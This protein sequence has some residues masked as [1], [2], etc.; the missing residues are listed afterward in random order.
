MIKQNINSTKFNA[1]Q[2]RFWFPHELKLR[3]LGQALLLSA[4]LT[5]IGCGGGGSS[6]ATNVPPG[7]GGG[8]GGGGGETN[9]AAFNA[10]LYPVLVNRCG[11]CHASQGPLGTPDFAHE[12]LATALG[13][14]EANTLA[15]LGNPA[16]SRLVTKLTL[17]LHRCGSSCDA[18]AEEL[19]VAIGAWST[20]VGGNNGGITGEDIVS[21]TLTIADGVQNG[22]AGRVET[23][24][25][26]KYEFKTGSGTTAF[27]TSGVAPALNLTF[28][29]DVTWIAGQGID[30]V[31][32]NNAEISKAV[33]T[34]EDSKK[35]YDMIAG[36]GGSKE[37]SIEAW[38]INDN[39]ADA[40][41]ARIVSYSTSSAA[42]NFTMGQITSYYNFRNRSD[43]SGANGTPALETDNNAD[44]LK[45]ELQ[46]I[47][48]TFDETNGRNIFVNGVI[49]PYQGGATDP[50][51]PALI[52]ADWDP[53]YT[54][55]LGNEVPDGTKRQWLGKMFFVAIYNRALTAAE[56]QQN[57][58]A[59]IGTKISLEFDVS[60]LLDAS[61]TTTSKISLDVSELDAFSYVFG[62]P[63]L[64]TD[65]V[66]PNIPVKNIRIGVNGN[67]PATAQAFR[68]VDMTVTASPTELSRLGSVIP[69]DTGPDTDQFTLVFE[70]LGSNTNVVVEP[71]PTATP[72]LTVNDPSPEAGLRTFEQI[73]NTMSVLT[74][75]ATS[76]TSATFDEIKQQLPSTPALGSF[77]SAH[78][79]GIAKLSLEYCSALVESGDQNGGLRT[80]FFGAAFEFGAAVSIA[81]SNQAK[82]DIITSNLVNKM[83]G[84]NLS[85]QPT[86]AEI[87]PDLDQLIGELT[88]GCNAPA[89][90]NATRTRTIVKAACAAVLGSAVVLIQ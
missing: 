84:I 38:I 37:Y 82:Q 44:D 30:I 63:V 49:V 85:S 69:K 18:W 52:G 36:A 33:A 7:G 34:P 45:T 42:R 78:Q 48:M 35:L 8:G 77:V 21:S 27:D 14:V 32:P 29:G 79:V 55:I 67:V 28:G 62:A 13:V 25:I 2:R 90:C 75:V 74:G 16:N 65:I 87:Q 11:G 15:N 3:H 5:L 61:G 10:T 17:E 12:D 31:D 24:V 56:V 71:I 76:D 68:N 73:N 54:F 88:V 70:V 58:L 46:H 60:T 41:P 89:D 43:Q 86:L 20:A 51:V 57:T 19:R 47:V 4:A 26:A 6:S 80:A 72:D 40:G 39:V 83:V 64:T 66:S 1:A 81:F 59:G 23:N 9:E 22:G 53:N 50:N